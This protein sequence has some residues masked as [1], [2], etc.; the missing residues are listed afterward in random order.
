M[1]F[2]VIHFETLAS[3]ND[4]AA[5]GIYRHGD[6]IVASYQSS[7]RGQRGNVWHSDEGKNLT[8]SLV[9][10][11][12]EIAA[13][14]QFLI[15]MMTS[16]AV[17]KTLESYGVEGVE[18]K[19]PNDILV[20]GQKISGILIEHN[21]LGC[22]LSRS[23]IGVGINVR[24]ESF[25][26]EGANPTSLSLQLGRMV[27]C[28][29]VLE[30]FLSTFKKLYPMSTNTDTLSELYTS[31]LYRREGLHP[32]IDAETHESFLATIESIDPNMGGITLRL[33]DNTHRTYYFKEVIFA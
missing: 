1:K 3:T 8:F 18:I 4:E 7:G 26:V 6:V 25:K 28:E 31:R 16:V 33:I 32:Y 29:E 2:K 27:K 10:E 22:E 20:R 12:R 15:S 19:W 23:I 13:S 14:S 21:L 11:P 5:N 9:V 30:R 24:Q 17:A